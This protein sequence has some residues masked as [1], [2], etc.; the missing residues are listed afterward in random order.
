MVFASATTRV[1]VS[2]I[3]PSPSNPNPRCETAE[4]AKAMTRSQHGRDFVL[5]DY[6]TRRHRYPGGLPPN[7]KIVSI[8]WPTPTNPWPASRSTV[9]MAARTASM[10]AFLVL[11]GSR[12]IGVEEQVRV[13]KDQR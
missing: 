10:T 8:A 7:A 2:E 11:L 13:D 9:P 3:R 5:Q 12:M 1:C 6:Q 4:H